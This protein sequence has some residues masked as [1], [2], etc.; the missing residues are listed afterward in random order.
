M[1]MQKKSSI[2]KIEPYILFYFYFVTCTSLIIID[3][4]G[5]A[6]AL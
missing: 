6:F 4:D 3:K 1:M 5:S 2:E